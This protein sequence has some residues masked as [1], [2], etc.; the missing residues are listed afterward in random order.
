MKFRPD[1]DERACG[2]SIVHRAGLMACL[3]TAGHDG[4]C[5]AVAGD[6]GRA[7]GVCWACRVPEGDEHRADCHARNK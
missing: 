7:D 1:T 3:R 5:V 2:K 6:A 4:E